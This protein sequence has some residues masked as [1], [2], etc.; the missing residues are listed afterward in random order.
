MG[1]KPLC[2]T[3]HNSIICDRLSVSEVAYCP[4][5]IVGGHTRCPVKV[6]GDPAILIQAGCLS[7]HVR[8]GLIG[9]IM[10]QS[11]NEGGFVDWFIK[12]WESLPCM[13]RWELG[14]GEIPVKWWESKRKGMFEN[15]M[16]KGEEK[17]RDIDKKRKLEEIS[18]IRR[19]ESGHMMN[20][21][22]D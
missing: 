6:I 3:Y 5:Q 2:M 16:E 14:H 13:S 20:K 8:E 9:G 7:G 18:D 10:S 4:G 17:L 12:T 1:Y 22:S 21:K 11:H 19:E 15:R